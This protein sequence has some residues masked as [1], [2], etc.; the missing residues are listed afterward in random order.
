MCSAMPIEA[1]WS[2][3]LAPCVYKK[4]DMEELGAKKMQLEKYRSNLAVVL[5]KA[6]L[7]QYCVQE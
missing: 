1:K 7:L 4:E 2:G 5:A 6:R 3:E